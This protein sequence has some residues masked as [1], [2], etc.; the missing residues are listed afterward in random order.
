VHA[1][2]HLELGADLW[3][4]HL[5]P[6]VPTF[7]LVSGFLIF[8]SLAA[9]RSLASYARK[10]ALRIYPALHVCFALCLVMLLAIGAMGWQEFATTDFAVWAV[11]QLTVAQFFP[12]GFL[13]DF[14]SGTLNGSLWTISVELQF[15]VLTPIAAFILG[16]FRWLWLPTIAVF[17]AINLIF[18]HVLPEE[19]MLTKMVGVTFLPWFYMFLIGGW[20]SSRPDVVQ[21]IRKTPLLVF[22]LAFA[23][24][25]LATRVFTTELGGNAINPVMYVTMAPLM[26]RLAYTLPTLSRTLLR[27]NDISYGLYIYHM[28]V[29][30]VAIWYGLTGSWSFALLA[31]GITVLLAMASWFLI[32]RPAL[33]LRASPGLAGVAAR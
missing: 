2:R 15:Y 31:F 14:A 24:A 3:Y 20:L 8:P 23:A 21:W 26:I 17:A 10:R 12:A 32:E 27:G 4:L 6:G 29:I 7:F 22:V 1:S 25:T 11:A 18:W 33:A 9:S 30:N 13:R 19:T 28:P 16:R 5:L